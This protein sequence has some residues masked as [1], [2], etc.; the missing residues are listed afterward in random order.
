MESNR[1]DVEKK[2]Q[3]MGDPDGFYSQ[4]DGKSLDGF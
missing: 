1:D 2:D 3:I 4:A